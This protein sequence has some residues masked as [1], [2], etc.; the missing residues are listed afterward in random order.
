[1]PCCSCPLRACARVDTRSTT[2][3]PGARCAPARSISCGCRPLARP[4]QARSANYPG[5]SRYCLLQLHAAAGS[6]V[7]E[8]S[9][10][11]R[12]GMRGQR[13]PAVGCPGRTQPPCGRD[14]TRRRESRR[15]R[16][17]GPAVA[18]PAPAFRARQHPAHAAAV[19]AEPLRLA[20]SRTDGSA[21]RIRRFE[22][23]RQPAPPPRSTWPLSRAS[24]AGNRPVWGVSATDA[25][26]RE[27][28]LLACLTQRDGIGIGDSGRVP[29]A[30]AEGLGH[31]S[32]ES[33][34]APARRG[35]TVPGRM[36]PRQAPDGP[37]LTR[38]GLLGPCAR[39]T[40]EQPRGQNG[41]IK[42]DL[43]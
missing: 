22:R 40:T 5:A 39:A 34:A 25:S 15:V 24:L 35:G 12:P 27:C 7:R 1:M 36:P 9:P 6:S 13:C 31:W 23:R 41:H 33:G 16:A 38:P 2:K 30:R 29:G 20:G 28:R 26:P 14:R 19:R 37:F 4:G 10:R 3:N 17:P 18:V 8:R 43:G 11:A 32:S 21:Q 42:N